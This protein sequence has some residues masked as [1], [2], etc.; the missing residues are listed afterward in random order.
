MDAIIYFPFGLYLAPYCGLRIHPKSDY[1]YRPLHIAGAVLQMVV[2]KAQAR[3]AGNDMAQMDL[4]RTTNR[5]FCLWQKQRQRLLK[6][7]CL[8]AQCLHDGKSQHIPFIHQR[9][10]RLVHSEL[11]DLFALYFIQYIGHFLSVFFIE[12]NHNHFF[13]IG[14]IGNDGQQIQEQV[15]PC[16]HP[17]RRDACK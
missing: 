17:L 4:D 14:R 11:D 6:L 10:I 12:R 16:H 9:Y 5:T 7:I 15:F 3:S 13:H 1:R 8:D 2:V